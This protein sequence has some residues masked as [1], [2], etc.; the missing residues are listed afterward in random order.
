MHKFIHVNFLKSRYLTIFSS[1]LLSENI[2]ETKIIEHSILEKELHILVSIMLSLRF[3]FKQVFVPT[4]WL[5]I[6]KNS[7]KLFQG[8]NTQTPYLQT[9]AR[10]LAFLGERNRRNKVYSKEQLCTAKFLKKPC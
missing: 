2:L 5:I 8:N 9:D 1:Q 10:I 7:C 3:H 4:E 6:C